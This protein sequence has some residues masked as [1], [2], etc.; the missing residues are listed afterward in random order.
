[1]VARVTVA[2]ARVAE[3]ERVQLNG[4]CPSRLVFGSPSM[5]CMM[6]GSS[7]LPHSKSASLPFFR[8]NM[9]RRWTSGVGRFQHDEIPFEARLVETLDVVGASLGDGDRAVGT[10]LTIC[11]SVVLPVADSERGPSVRCRRRHRA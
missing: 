5:L 11:D 10:V 9:S 4:L 8:G 3:V 6:I 2:C 1:M 7:A